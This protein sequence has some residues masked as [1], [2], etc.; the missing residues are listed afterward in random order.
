MIANVGKL[1]GKIAENGYNNGAFAKAIGMSAVT[2]RRKMNEAEY[3]FSIG[4]SV[5][6]KNLLNLTDEEYLAIFVG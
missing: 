2:L 3:D 5:E 6:V 4:E 1:K